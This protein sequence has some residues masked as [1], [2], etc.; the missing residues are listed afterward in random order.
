MWA[1][2]VQ[3]K[4]VANFNKIA[5]QVSVRLCPVRSRSPEACC[6]AASGFLCA[7]GLLSLSLQSAL[8]I[9]VPTVDE[10]DCRWAMTAQPACPS[11]NGAVRDGLFCAHI[12]RFIAS[13]C[14]TSRATFRPVRS[15]DLTR[16]QLEALGAKLW[17]MANFLVRLC[18]RI[19][20]GRFPRNDELRRTVVDAYGAMHSLHMAM[21]YMC[22]G[23]RSDGCAPPKEVGDCL[24]DGNTFAN[25]KWAKSIT[26]G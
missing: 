9:P 22:C 25:G 3:P 4:T 15:Q 24:I 6:P 7:H 12:A 17:P 18:K 1:K 13:F 20:R 26:F 14:A 2:I 5:D 23:T 8:S 10:H 11:R 19:D 16:E 21:H